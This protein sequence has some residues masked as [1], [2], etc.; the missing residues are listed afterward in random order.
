M[1]D[2]YHD[3]L[4]Q[5]PPSKVFQ[6]IS[7]PAGLDR[8]WTQDSQGSPEKG[9][10]YKLD[11][12]PEYR[13]RAEVSQCVAD[14]RFELHLTDAHKDWQGTRVGFELE[15]QGDGATQ[16]RFHHLGWPEANDHYRRS[17]YCW[18]MYL[19]LLKGWIESGEAVPYAERLNA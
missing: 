16:V 7:T 1:P 13:W 9:S 14:K 17:C 19:R 6:S 2:I 18:A 3:F 12:G 11:F 8:W 10:E 4:I 15:A 5:A